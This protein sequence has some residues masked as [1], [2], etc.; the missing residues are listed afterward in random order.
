LPG[1]DPRLENNSTLLENI[2]EKAM[3]DS[4]LFESQG[5]SN[6]LWAY[7]K[8]QV[9]HPNL[10]RAFGDA[11]VDMPDFTAFKPQ[12]L[13][14]T[15]W[16]FAT[17]N[18]QHTD[19]FEMFGD[20]IIQTDNLSSFKPSK[21]LPIIILWAYATAGVKHVELFNL[22]GDHIDSLEDL[23]QFNPQA[24]SNI[25]WSFATIEIQHTLG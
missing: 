3:N 10:F 14:N 1:Y 17:V 2:A 21:E 19:L 13:A 18:I 23:N 8:T 6:T 9:V 22:V 12:E 25:V 24:L 15:I 16:A 20:Y 11:I 4:A 5:Y 7:A